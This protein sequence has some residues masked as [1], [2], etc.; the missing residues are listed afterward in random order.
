MFV[1]YDDPVA[2]RVMLTRGR[3]IGPYNEREPI[4]G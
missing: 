3:L 2:R 4:L 1:T